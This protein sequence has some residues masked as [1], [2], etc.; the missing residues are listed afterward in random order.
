MITHS[1]GRP[2]FHLHG[3]FGP[4]AGVTAAEALAEAA[5]PRE[6]IQH[7]DV[8]VN[9]LLRRGRGLKDGHDIGS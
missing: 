1:R 2:G 3:A 4:V 6:K 8:L 5:D 7:T 9:R